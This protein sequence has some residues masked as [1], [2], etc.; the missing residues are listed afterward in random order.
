M[1]RSPFAD[2]ILRNGRFNT[3]DPGNPVADAVAIKEGRFLAVGAEPEVMP[4]AGPATR[5]VDLKGRSVLPGLR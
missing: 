1:N 3:L 2:T 4:L 5:I